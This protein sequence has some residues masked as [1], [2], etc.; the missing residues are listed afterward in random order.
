VTTPEEHEDEV[1][2]FHV[3]GFLDGEYYIAYN[4]LTSLGQSALDDEVTTAEIEQ[5]AIDAWHALMRERRERA[6]P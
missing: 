5:D 3:V 4:S 1:A 2:T 6:A